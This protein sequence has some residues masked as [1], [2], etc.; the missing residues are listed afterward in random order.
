[1]TK[2]A[3]HSS[4]LCLGQTQLPWKA[5]LLLLGFAALVAVSGIESG[6][7]SVYDWMTYDAFDRIDDRYRAITAQNCKSKPASE[8]R[9]PHDSV[10]QLPMFNRLLS[11][12]VYPNRTKLLHVHNMALNR[13]FFF[14]Q[15]NNV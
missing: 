12:I 5:V 11:Y 10:G 4:W 7:P 14:R 9:L 15:V 2:T 8:L 13:A 3:T 6:D 1:M